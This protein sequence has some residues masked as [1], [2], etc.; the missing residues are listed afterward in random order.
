MRMFGHMARLEGRQD[1]LPW[2]HRVATNPCLNLRR[3]SGRHAESELT[4]DR[5]VAVGREDDALPDRRLAHQ[6]LSWKV[7]QRGDA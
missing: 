5:V 7:L 6:L 1:V 2:I 3:N 4:P